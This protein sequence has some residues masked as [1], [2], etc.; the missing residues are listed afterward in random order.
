MFVL[1]L[2]RVSG[3]WIEYAGPISWLLH[4]PDLTPLDSILK[5]FIRHQV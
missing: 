5:E 1:V 2:A 3:K 4:F